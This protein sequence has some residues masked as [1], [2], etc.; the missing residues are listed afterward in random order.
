MSVRSAILALSLVLAALPTPCSAQAVE[1]RAPVKR[2]ELGGRIQFQWNTTS[3]DGEKSSEFVLRRARIWAGTQ[4]N[5]WVD[6][7]VQVDVSG[8]TAVARYVFIRMSLSP[9]ARIAFGQFKRGFDVF[10]LTSSADILVVERDGNVRGAFDCAG[11]GGVCSFS[12]FSE[13]LQFSSLDAGIFFQGETAGRKLGYYLSVTNGPGLNTREENGTKSFSGRVEWL[14]R[15]RLKLAANAG[16]HDYPNEVTERDEYAPAVGADVEVGSFAQG[17]HLQAGVL[18]GENWLNLDGR[19]DGSRFVTLQG[20]ATWKIP[21]KKAGRIGA[22]EPLVRVS[23]GDPD[24]GVSSDG[25]FLL[26]PGILFHIQGKNKFGANLDVWRP[27]R[28]TT[29]VGLKAQTYLYF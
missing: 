7:A 21:R 8:A 1:P 24:R 4:I 26:T 23:W 14:P 16:F 5:D 11:V 9:A 12:R 2:T 15:E 25:G 19:G 20:I 13:K 3:A 27:Q 29:V 6:G 28:G 18:A 17:F 22:V 10:E